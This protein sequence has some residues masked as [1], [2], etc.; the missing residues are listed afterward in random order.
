MTVQ[1]PLSARLARRLREARVQAGLTVREAAVLAGLSNHT[2]FVKYANG[3]VAL[4]WESV[5][6]FRGVSEG[7]VTRFAFAKKEPLRAELEAFRDT[8]LGETTELSTMA[9]AAHTLEVVESALRSATEGGTLVV[10]VPD[11]A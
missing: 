1:E 11:E 3:T 8:V 5:T 4:E 6:T 10:T 7:D 2:L 9:E